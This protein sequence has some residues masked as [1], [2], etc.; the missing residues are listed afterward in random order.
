MRAV[1][2]AVVAPES[3]ACGNSNMGGL[4]NTVMGTS[5][6]PQAAAGMSSLLPAARSVPPAAPDDHNGR[7]DYTGPQPFE[8]TSAQTIPGYTMAVQPTPEDG[9]YALPREL[10][11]LAGPQR[12]SLHDKS[13]IEQA[14]GPSAEPG[15]PKPLQLKEPAEQDAYKSE[16]ISGLQNLPLAQLKQ[17]Y[18][19]IAS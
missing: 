18:A 13:N 7:V 3:P 6:Q 11:N 15:L 5:S 9:R 16:V 8:F 1:V 10:E 12:A 4:L 19:Q 17:I 14:P 2:V